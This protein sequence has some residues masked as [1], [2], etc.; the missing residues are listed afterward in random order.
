[1]IDNVFPFILEK[2]SNKTESTK[3][4]CLE[5]LYEMVENFNIDNN[6]M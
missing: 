5:L 1:M 2:L 4:E 3:I 6:S